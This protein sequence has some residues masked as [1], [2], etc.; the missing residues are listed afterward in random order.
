MPLREYAWFVDRIRGNESALKGEDGYSL[1]KAIDKAINEMPD[2]FAIKK[3]IAANRA[4]VK[5]MCLTEYDEME[6]MEL[7]REESREEGREEGKKEDILA[8]MQKLNITAREAM[9]LLNIPKEK[10]A[11]FASMMQ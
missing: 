2:G 5:D 7:F 9:E 10:Q 3:F 6:T 8:L 1:E 11:L 4:E